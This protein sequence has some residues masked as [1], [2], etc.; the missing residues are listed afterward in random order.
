MVTSYSKMYKKKKKSGGSGNDPINGGDNTGG[1]K[2]PLG[3]D[4]GGGRFYKGET[5]WK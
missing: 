1:G 3:G 2:L 5:R 4:M